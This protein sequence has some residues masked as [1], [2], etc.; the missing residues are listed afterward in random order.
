MKHEIY[1][2]LGVFEEK[3]KKIIHV[4]VMDN[5]YVHASLKV[6]ISWSPFHP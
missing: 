3:S 5:L 4:P 1:H 6:L 2:L